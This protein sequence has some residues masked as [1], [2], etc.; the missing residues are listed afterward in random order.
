MQP[1]RTNQI[2]FPKKRK[3]EQKD[4]EQA[5]GCDHETVRQGRQRRYTTSWGP[6]GFKKANHPLAIMVC[7]TLLLSASS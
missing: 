5:Y 2:D 3:K 7:S 6:V 1:S 4:E